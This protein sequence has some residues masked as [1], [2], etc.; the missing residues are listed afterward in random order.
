MLI[1]CVRRHDR[2]SEVGV[3]LMRIALIAKPRHANTGVGRYVIELER[4][5]GAQGHQI[6]LVHPIVPCPAWVVRGVRR[7]SLC[8][9]YLT[10]RFAS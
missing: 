6:T 9:N 7:W 8:T 5:L 3:E 4:E 1:C 2:Q 10:K